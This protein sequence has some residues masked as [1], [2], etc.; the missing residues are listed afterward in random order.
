MSFVGSELLLLVLVRSSVSTM[1]E[2]VKARARR[3]STNNKTTPVLFMLFDLDELLLF[4][5]LITFK[6]LFRVRNCSWKGR[7]TFYSSE[8]RKQF[9]ATTFFPFM[10]SSSSKLMRWLLYPLRDNLTSE[11]WKEGEKAGTRGNGEGDKGGGG[12]GRTK[13]RS[14]EGKEMSENKL[15]E[16]AWHGFKNL[17]ICKKR[18]I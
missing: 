15:S 12:G 14:D 2:T 16:N 10:P 3:S 1:M 4:S 13:T 11:F 8:H 7:F 5:I 9:L 18:L 6:S 17:N